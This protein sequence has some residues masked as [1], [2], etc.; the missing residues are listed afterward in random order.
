MLTEV[1]GMLNNRLVVPVSPR[2]ITHFSAAHK[3]FSTPRFI[4]GFVEPVGLSGI[5]RQRWMQANHVN[6]LFWRKWLR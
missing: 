6:G 2:D 3:A 4:S 5:Y 1:D